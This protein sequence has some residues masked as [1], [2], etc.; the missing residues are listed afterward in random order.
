MS[1]EPAKPPNSLDWAPV[2]PPITHHVVGKIQGCTEGEEGRKGTSQHAATTEKGEE[3]EE[4]TMLA[5][6]STDNNSIGT[7]APVF[8]NTDT[9]T[10]YEKRLEN[11]RL[12]KID[13]A[14]REPEKQ[15]EPYQGVHY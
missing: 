12:R 2:R 13:M 7:G 11:L 10:E 14:K 1:V 15:L 8:M 9:P 4:G 5:N 3:E 6:T